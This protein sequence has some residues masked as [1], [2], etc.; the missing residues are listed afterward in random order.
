[1]ILRETGKLCT[2]L[3]RE[4]DAQ[5]AVAVVRGNRRIF[6]EE[7]G[8]PAGGTGGRRLEDL[9]GRVEAGKG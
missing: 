4:L 9:G 8:G 2:K 3:R 6:A 1:M 5:R 7:A